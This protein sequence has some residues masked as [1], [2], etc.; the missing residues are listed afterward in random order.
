[1]RNVAHINASPSSNW[2]RRR[3]RPARSGSLE[4]LQQEALVSPLDIGRTD[5]LLVDEVEDVDSQHPP[6]P[7]LAIELQALI[8]VEFDIELT[9]FSLAEVDILL[10]DAKESSPRRPHRRRG[11]GPSPARPE[12]RP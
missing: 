9:G 3:T 1:M 12:L 7:L 4:D 5:L 6:P 10:D 2:E 11:R 8:D